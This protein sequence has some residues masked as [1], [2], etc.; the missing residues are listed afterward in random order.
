MRIALVFQAYMNPYSIR[1][2]CVCIRQLHP[3]S[4]LRGRLNKALF[5]APFFNPLQFFDF[6]LCTPAKCLVFRETGHILAHVF[7]NM[8]E[9]KQFVFVALVQYPII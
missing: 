4:I 1:L 9:Q 8:A 2:N 6:P 7:G 3:A 5:N